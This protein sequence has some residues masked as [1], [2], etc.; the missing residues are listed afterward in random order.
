M[1]EVIEQLNNQAIESTV[2]EFV[3]TITL[4][5]NSNDYEHGFKIYYSDTWEPVSVRYWHV[6]LAPNKDKRYYND[7]VTS[8]DQ[9]TQ[10]LA[11][12]LANSI[13]VVEDKRDYKVVFPK[14]P[15]VLMTEL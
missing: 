13:T 11:W 9:F 6:I 14:T 5:S 10:V 2:T 7:T 15:P 3:E 8:P 4:E 1:N 12:R